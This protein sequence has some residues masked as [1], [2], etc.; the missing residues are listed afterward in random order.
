MRNK[1]GVILAMAWTAIVFLVSHGYVQAL[2]SLLSIHTNVNNPNVQVF[3][4]V[5]AGQN[6]LNSGSFLP[7]PPAGAR[8]AVPQ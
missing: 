5:S 1:D 7:Q 8:P 2:Q 6:Y 3:P 4:S